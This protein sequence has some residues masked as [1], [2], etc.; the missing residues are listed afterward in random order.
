MDKQ[1][2]FAFYK[3]KKY[4]IPRPDNIRIKIEYKIH[5]YVSYFKKIQSTEVEKIVEKSVSNEKRNGHN[6]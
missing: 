6:G 4:L 1:A 2:C 3:G 5:E